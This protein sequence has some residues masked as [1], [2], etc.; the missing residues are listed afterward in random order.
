LTVNDAPKVGQVVDH[1]FLWANEEAAGQVEGRKS[2]PCIIVAVEP[3]RETG[4]PRVTVVPVTSQ[5]PRHGTSAV[6]I[7]TEIKTRLGLDRRRRAWVVADEVNVFEWPGFDLVPQAAGSFVCATVTRGFFDLVRREV[8]A[9]HVAS[10]QR[11]VS[12]DEE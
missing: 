7:P 11:A 10:R 9:A 12:R 4:H 8:L 3:R 1:F 2:R 5:A 6:E